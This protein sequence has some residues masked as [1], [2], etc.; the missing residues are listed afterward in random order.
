[1]PPQAS[2]NEAQRVGLLVSQILCVEHENP[3][4]L[5]IVQGDFNKGNLTQEPNTDNSSNVLPE[6]GTLWIT[7]TLQPVKHTM[8]SPVQQ[9]RI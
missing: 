3:D 8:R 7:A 2:A 9:G 4:S 1:M 6:K 5:V